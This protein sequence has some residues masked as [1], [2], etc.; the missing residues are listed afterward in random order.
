MG[1]GGRLID[2]FKKERGN[3][4]KVNGG[5]LAGGVSFKPE[6]YLTSWLEYILA[7]PFTDSWFRTFDTQV[8]HHAHHDYEC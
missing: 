2:E 6:T 4:Y 3:E 5:T 8:I 7:S 1:V